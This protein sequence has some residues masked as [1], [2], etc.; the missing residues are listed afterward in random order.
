ML[1]KL[2]VRLGIW[3]VAAL[4]ATQILAAILD[5]L[6]RDWRSY[7]VLMAISIVCYLALRGP[8]HRHGSGVPRRLERIPHDPSIHHR[9][10]PP[11]ENF[12]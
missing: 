10:E 9:Y 1:P 2:L 3:V 4:T 6:V 8:A 7:A 11:A 5:V 12:D